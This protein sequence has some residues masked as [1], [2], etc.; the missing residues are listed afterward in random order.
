[1]RQPSALWLEFALLI[2]ATGHSHP[3]LITASRFKHN[4]VPSCHHTTTLHSNQYHAITQLCQEPQSQGTKP[5]RL[6]SSPSR[7]L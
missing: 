7:L 2:Y 4:R 3:W 5:W 6:T 1:M